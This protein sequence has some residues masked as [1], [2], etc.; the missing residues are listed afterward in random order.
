MKKTTTPKEKPSFPKVNWMVI[1]MTVFLLYAVNMY[2]FSS[3]ILKTIPYSDFLQKIDEGNI[4]SVTILDDKI[5]GVFK[6][7]SDKKVEQF[8]TIAPRDSNYVE[9]LQSKNVIINV[10]SKDNFLGLLASWVL[11]ILFFYFLW[12][13]VSQRFAGAPPG[14]LSMSRS[15]AKTNLETEVKTTF[16]DVAGIDE[17]REELSEIVNFLQDPKRY[18]RLGGRAPKGVLLI[19]PPG[20]GKTLLAR[21]VAGEAKVPFFSINGSEFVEMFVGLGAARVRDLFEQARREAPCILFIDEIDALGKSRAFGAFGSGANDEKEQTLNQLLAEMDGFDSSQGV[22]M[23]AATNR[24]EILDPALLRAGRF[25]RQILLSP[26]D[27]LG[28]FQ[29]LSVHVKKIKLDPSVDLKKIAAMT[30]GFSGADIANL[31]NEAAIVATRRNAESVFEADFAQAIERIIAGLE[32]KTRVMSPEEKKRVAFHELG[33]A[34]VALALRVPERVQKISIIP[35]GFSALG[36]TLQRPLED[37]YLLDEQ[38]LL[39]KISVLLGGRAAESVIFPN[40]STGAADDLAK[41]SDIARSMVVQFGMSRAL[42]LESFDVKRSPYLDPNFELSPSK[43][44]QGTARE[45]DLE[46]KAI[47]EKAM[48]TSVN[49]ILQNRDFID[50]AAAELLMTETLDETRISQLW[51][52]RTAQVTV[53]GSLRKNV[54]PQ[55]GASNV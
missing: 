34:T 52:G 54:S 33:H 51:Q 53:N 28:R 17:A 16:A 21:A 14:L 44:S 30:P 5:H 6:P 31:V 41:A 12:K 47:L 7:S 49:V 45:I 46:V 39:N 20:T 4:K 48:I 35:R 1:L 36:Y 40:I 18:T 15:K 8:V 50:K 25:D 10:E 22:I 11:P 32:K 29:I 2:F 23:L 43:V 26:P 27:Q 13:F 3:T 38:E 42:G 24:P 19:G 9:K 37:R 55:I